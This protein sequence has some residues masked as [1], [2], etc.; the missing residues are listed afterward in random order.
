LRG[1]SYDVPSGLFHWA[2]GPNDIF[3]FAT[4]ESGNF[5]LRAFLA[6]V[7]PGDRRRLESLARQVLENALPAFSYQYRLLGVDGA[8][9]KFIVGH[10][11]CEFNAQ[12]TVQSVYGTVV[13]VTAQERLREDAET[14]SAQLRALKESGI[15][16]VWEQDAEFRFTA[17]S[18][19][20]DQ[21]TSAPNEAAIGLHRWDLPDARPCQ[22]SWEEHRRVLEARES[23][24]GFEYQIGQTFVSVTGL[25]MFSADGAFLG[26]RGT[27]HDIT[28]QKRAEAAAHKTEKL[29]RLASR[30]G[31]IGAW[32][33]EIPSLEGAWT[34]ELMS[35]YEL[36][37]YAVLSVKMLFDYVHHEWRDFVRATFERCWRLGVN[38]DIEFLSHTALGRAMWLHLMAEPVRDDDGTVVRVKGALQDI[39]ERKRD[40]ERLRQLSSDLSATFESIT[41]ALLTVDTGMRCLYANGEAQRLANRSREELLGRPVSELFPCFAT[42][43]FESELKG[44]M[45][46]GRT[47]HLELASC[48]ADAQKW[49]HVTLY[50]STQGITLILRD[51]TESRAAQLA[52]ERSEERYRLLFETSA[53]GIIKVALGTRIRVANRAACKMFRTTPE[54]MRELRSIELV[55]PSDGRLDVMIQERLRSGGSSGELTMLRADGSTFEAEVNTSTYTASDGNTYY[56][57][58]I[59]DVTERV[60]LRRK[61]E[62]LNEELTLRVHERTLELERANS[63]L[64]GF[65]RSLAH[66]L[67]QPIAAAKAFSSAL[68]DALDKGNAEEARRHATQ[69][70]VSARTMGS[71]VEA[72]LSLAHISQV[73]LEIEEVDLS[74]IANSLLDELHGQTPSRNLVRHIEAEMYAEGDVTLLRMLLQNLLGNAWKFSSRRDV[75]EICFYAERDAKEDVVYC[76]RDNGAGFDM[77]QASKLFGT[78]QRL[79]SH[80][81]F[82]G[83]GIGLAN[84]QRIVARHGGRIWA[85]SQPGVGTIF[86]FTLGQASGPQSR[87]LGLT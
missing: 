59:R 87:L 19:T 10:G 84:A 15:V 36:Q 78:F 33:V 25:P 17:I 12:G 37:P 40:A 56:N 77:A 76:V 18:K 64:K 53:D 16:W 29:L 73:S 41:D 83:T 49:L 2:S 70:H 42:P 21:V 26:Y 81:E 34:P 46:T 8:A 31:R 51:V 48:L 11:Q 30:L 66:D 38:V 55:S 57:L 24:H 75:A 3:N 79:H 82:P 7:H 23:F 68:L 58:V 61:M 45:Q 50:P 65:A 35:I 71:Y 72:L 85:Q 9:D 14:A 27:A 4:E 47:G 60:R 6:R 86:R 1:W 22:G 28:A 39:T 54:R 32:T 44:V 80:A 63:E 74:A 69:V 52:L 20:R 13:D 5:T 43:G 62:A 67:R